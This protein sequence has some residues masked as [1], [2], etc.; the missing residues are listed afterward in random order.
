[1]K[2][3]APVPVHCFRRLGVNSDWA[4]S[5]LDAPL[6][7]ATASGD[8]SPHQLCRPPGC[9]RWPTRVPVRSSG[10]PLATS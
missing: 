8:V 10:G 5:G 9:T 6:H 7:Q 4:R 1:M 2:R 3:G